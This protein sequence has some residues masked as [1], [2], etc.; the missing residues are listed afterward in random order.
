M[1]NK[2]GSNFRVKSNALIVP[3]ENNGFL[4]LSISSFTSPLGGGVNYFY[5]NIYDGNNNIL[6]GDILLG[7]VSVPWCGTGYLG[8][9]TKGW[10][11]GDGYLFGLNDDGLLTIT[12]MDYNGNILNKWSFDQNEYPFVR[13]RDFDFS[14]SSSGRLFTW[15]EDWSY[16]FFNETDTVDLIYSFK[17]DTSDIFSGSVPVERFFV[18]NNWYLI[19][20]Q[21]KTVNLSDSTFMLFTLKNDSL[22]LKSRILNT[23]N[24]TFHSVNSIYLV[25]TSSI[26]FDENSLSV[27]KFGLVPLNNDNFVLYIEIEFADYYQ[28]DV[29]VFDKDGSMLSHYSDTTT[30]GKTFGGVPFAVSEEEFIT[31]EEHQNDVYTVRN[32]YF[33][34]ID[35]VKINDDSTGSND[36]APM[37]TTIGESGYF[38]TWENET[39]IYGR[40][41]NIDGTPDGGRIKLDGKQCIFFGENTCINFW[42]KMFKDY[43]GEIGFTIYDGEWNKIGEDTIATGSYYGIEF[44][45]KKIG[46]SNFV[47]IYKREKYT[48][49]ALF[50]KEGNKIKDTTLTQNRSYLNKI[51]IED[52][53]SFWVKWD[54]NLRLYSAALEPLTDVYMNEFTHYLGNGK[55][56]RLLVDYD[57]FGIVWKGLILSAQGDTLTGDFEFSE[58]PNQSAADPQFIPLKNTSEFAVLFTKYSLGQGRHIYW[59]VYGY[60]GKPRPSYHR[61]NSQETVYAKNVYTAINGNDVFFTWADVREGNLGYDIYGNIYAKDAITGINVKDQPNA[62]PAEFK[63]YQNYPNPFNPSTTITYTISVSETLHATSQQLVQLKIYDILGGEVATLVNK[64]QTPGNYEVTFNAKNLPSGIY[65]Y[66]LKAG[67]FNQTRKMILLR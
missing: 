50:D 24:F 52:N 66:R 7:I 57:E 40:K 35:K 62:I 27:D 65:I 23:D 22:I 44:D 63:L 48:K 8:V 19:P 51:F 12:N 11:S 67:G 30:V 16:D 59:Q 60:D 13:I 33:D 54:N 55:F 64:K 42:K 53:E 43:H 6:T 28:Y 45:A 4:N 5:G 10:N 41:I 61:I 26:N 29:L 32:K 15:V 39:G 21:I 9:Q 2:T 1:G 36:I 18:N 20:L 49:L 37:V 3:G 38:V 47:A 58:I 14:K 56:L 46:D 25:D 31:A 34:E 17:T